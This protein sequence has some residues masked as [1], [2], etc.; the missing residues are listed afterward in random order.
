MA[1]T[2]TV[3][4]RALYEL[5]KGA[6]NFSTHT[7]KMIL[8]GFAFVFNHVDHQVYADVDTEEQIANGNGYTTGGYTL[9]V[10]PGFEWAQ[11]GGGG[12]A[13]LNW[14]EVEVTA[15]GGDLEFSGAIIYDYTH[16]SKVLVSCIELG[17]TVTVASGDTFVFSDLGFELMNVVA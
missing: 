8:V 12:L 6:I 13:Y 7:F 17:E 5:G 2:K 15:S 3:T 14:A 9:S 16:A 4:E 1:L 10:L 11:S